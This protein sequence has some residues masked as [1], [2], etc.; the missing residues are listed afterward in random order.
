MSNNEYP[1]KV[2]PE[3]NVPQTPVVKVE[4]TESPPQI[5]LEFVTGHSEV[6]I[7][8]NIESVVV[9]IDDENI[10][11]GGQIETRSLASCVGYAL[12]I[13]TEK[14]AYVGH[15][16]SQP[17]KMKWEED[18]KR[19]MQL[20][21]EGKVA[22]F[23]FGGDGSPLADDMVKKFFVRL[24][25]YQGPGRK[26]PIFCEVSSALYRDLS[27]ETKAILASKASGICIETSTGKV[28]LQVDQLP[29]DELH[30]TLQ[31][32]YGN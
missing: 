30:A 12:Y 13:P 21:V 11:I 25:L 17:K 22:T 10:T 6:P 3:A 20:A 31:E 29:N 5:K 4:R 1:P 2:N 15:F 9:G 19:I 24:S 7:N 28:R 14:K 26:M 16:N 32:T 23:I 18:R 8:P 27:T